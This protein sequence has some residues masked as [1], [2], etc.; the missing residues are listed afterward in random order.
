[1]WLL[2]VLSDA[3]LEGT[4]LVSWCRNLDRIELKRFQWINVLWLSEH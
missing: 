4:Q 1:M 3:G 2:N